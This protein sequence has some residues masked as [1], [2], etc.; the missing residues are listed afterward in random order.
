MLTKDRFYEIAYRALDEVKAQLEDADG[1]IDTFN[2][3]TQGGWFYSDGEEEQMK[4]DAIEIGH[5]LKFINE[6]LEE[7]KS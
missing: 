6:C 5:A 7:K 3:R 2:Y 1:D 4:E